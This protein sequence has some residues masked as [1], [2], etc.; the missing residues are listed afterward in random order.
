MFGSYLCAYQSQGKT[1]KIMIT[2]LEM[3][4]FLLERDGTITPFGSF[5]CSARLYVA[6]LL[7]ILLSRHLFALGSFDTLSALLSYL[8]FYAIFSSMRYVVLTSMI[9][10]LCL[11][12]QSCWSSSCA[13]LHLWF[14]FISWLTQIKFKSF[15]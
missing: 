3:L 14:E 11:L 9:D 1:F 2:Y 10:E 15:R 4:P 7:L 6:L 12:V 8:L 13:F 5:P